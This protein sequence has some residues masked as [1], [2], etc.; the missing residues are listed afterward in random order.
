MKLGD[1]SVQN[2]FRR[3]EVGVIPTDTLYGLAAPAG[4]EAAV[5]KLYGL[6][7]RDTN[8]GTIIAAD[9]E[10]LVALGLKRSYLK[11]VAHYWPNPVSIIIPNFELKYL[12]LG[13][14]GLAVRIPKDDELTALLKISGPLLTTSANHPG[15]PPAT[16]L[17]AAKK[18]FGD[19]VDFYVDG[20]DLDG[21][22][23]S[24]IMRIV[25]DAVEIIREGA[26]KIKE[27]GDIV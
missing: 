17:A 7:A 24:T 19:S 23:P 27:N 20:G 9:I 4:N 1:E 16:T 18:Y 10:Q 11:P 6:K 2:A 22:R 25:D 13:K 14:G 21:R 5:N 26:I 3:G 15:E 8:P 12:H